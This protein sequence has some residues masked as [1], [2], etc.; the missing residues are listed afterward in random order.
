MKAARV[1]LVA[2]C[3]VV[4]LA[5]QVSALPQLAWRGIVPDLGLLVVVGT[6]LTLGARFAMVTGFG[7]GLLLDL[8]P[9]A[10]HIAGRW[11]LAL[12]LV[13]YLAGRARSSIP[14]ERT[15][16]AAV[17]AAAS[18][19][20][21]STFALSGMLLGEVATGIPGLLGVV[22]VS[23]VYDVLLGLIVVPAVWRLLGLT[24]TTR[25]AAR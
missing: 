1:A 19:V 8:A 23:V 12:V 11:A 18:F 22:A 16:V 24:T 2:A 4:A 21:T 5:L 6:G 17:T 10:D 25:L 13:G 7:T 9:P 20:G 14:P 15:T 3:V